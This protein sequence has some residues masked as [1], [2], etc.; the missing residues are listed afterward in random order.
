M[1]RLTRLR[2]VR[3]RRVMS[4][5][6]LAAA[7]GVAQATVAQATLSRLEQGITSAQPRTL[8]KLARALRVDPVELIGNAEMVSC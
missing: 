1:P 5:L 7:T 8:R 2:V 4:Q 3:E 6:D